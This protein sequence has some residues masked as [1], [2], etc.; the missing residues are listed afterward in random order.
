MKRL[1]IDARESGTSTGRYV[2]KLI[3]YLARLK[4][5]L[6]IAVLTKSHRLEFMKKIA[7][8]FEVIK[9][10]YKEFTFAEQFGLAWQLYKLKPDLVHF[11]MTQQPVLYFGKSITTVHDLTTARFNNPDKNWLVFKIKQLVYKLVIRRAA[12]KSKLVLTPSEFVKK[13][14]ADFAGTSSNKIR[15]TYEAADKILESA[16]KY[17]ALDGKK[18]IM[19]VGRPTPHKNLPRL[20]EAF[21][22]VRRSV[23]EL[24]LVLV[25]KNDANFE[26]L[27]TYAKNRNLDSQV[28]FTGFIDEGQLRWLYENAASYAFPSLSEGFGLPALEAMVYG[29]PVVSS[30]STCLPEIYGDAAEYFDPKNISDMADKIL[31]V[32]TEEELAEKLSKKGRAQAS[33]YSWQKMAEQTLGAYK[34]VLGK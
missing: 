13:D 18:F 20:V 22:I 34:E 25:G 33:K 5:D 14:L 21:N 28:I 12:H 7:P 8:N 3:E 15:V 31:K 2:D 32:L 19:Y 27:K 26:R 23:P 17:E 6:E 24:R 4:P 29:V 9:S 16:E 11:S 1:V 30:N 10:D